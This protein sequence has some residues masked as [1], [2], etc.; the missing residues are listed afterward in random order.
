MIAPAA[1]PFLE[2]GNLALDLLNTAETSDGDVADALV[3]PA[4]LL[5]W[6]QA[7][8]LAS[9]EA[10]GRLASPPT[11]RILLGET[12]RLRDDVGAVVEALG[13]REPVPSHVVY[14]L[15][16]A[17]AASRVS[18]WLHVAG[19]RTAVVDMETGESLLTLLA[20]IA[21]AAADLIV[22]AAPARIRRCASGTCTRWFHDTSKGGRRRWCSMATCGNRAKAASHR[23]RHA[24]A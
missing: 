19:A 11:M 4:G 7:A 20:P 18:P 1:E 23:R 22:D 13:R 15:N 6:L 2:S 3:S 5:A 12:Q 16:R 17:L 24:S 9:P 21:R 14:A 10:L 8:G